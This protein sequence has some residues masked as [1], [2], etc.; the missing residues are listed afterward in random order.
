LLGGSLAFYLMFVLSSYFGIESDV[1]IRQYDQTVIIELFVSCIITL[2]V[3]LYVFCALT[4]L[5]YYRTKY[6][7]G[8]I[9]RSELIDIAFKSLYPQRWQKGL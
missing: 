5:L 3:C 2:L 6:K 8:Y 7:K 9:S 4:A 1:P